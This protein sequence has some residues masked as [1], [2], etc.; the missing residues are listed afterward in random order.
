M[1]SS[2]EN[3]ETVEKGSLERVSLFLCINGYKV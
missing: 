2:P 1:I 3:P